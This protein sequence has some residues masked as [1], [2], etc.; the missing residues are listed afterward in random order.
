MHLT[1]KVKPISM[2]EYM[3]EYGQNV[4]DARTGTCENKSE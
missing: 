3:Y 4:Q 2:Y 1:R